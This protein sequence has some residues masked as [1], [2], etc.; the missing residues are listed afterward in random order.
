MDESLDQRV[1]AV[2]RC[3]RMVEK[4]APNARGKFRRCEWCG[5][6][7]RIVEPMYQRAFEVVYGMGGVRVAELARGGKVPPLPQT[8]AD[9][10]TFSLCRASGCWLIEPVDG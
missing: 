10:G 3:G 7:V 5:S 4:V 1:W 8:P 2:C 6:C 9:G